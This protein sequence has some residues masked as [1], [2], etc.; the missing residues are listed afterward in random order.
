MVDKVS[1]VRDW[2]SASI[3]DQMLIPGDYL[4]IVAFYGKAEVLVSEAVN[5]D[6][7]KEAVK[8]K[9]SQISGNGRFT[10]IG[11]ALDAIKA[12]VAQRE[13]DGRGK[14][15]LLLTDGIQEAPPTSKYYSKDGSFNHEFLQNTKTIPEKGWKVVILG[16]GNDTQ[17]RDLASQLK[18]S[19]AEVSEK[20]TAASIAEAAGGVFDTIT[21]AEPARLSPVR[22]GGSSSVT[23]ALKMSGP[24]A[25]T[26]V[27]VSG[28]SATVGSRQ[29]PSLISAPV[30]LD[31]R[32]DTVTKLNFPVTFPPDLPTG[33]A[34]GT[35][36][37]SFSS[38]ATFSPATLPVNVAVNTPLQ[39]NLVWVIV[40]AAVV[41]VLVAAIVLVVRLLA[42][43]RPVSFVLVIDGEPVGEGPSTL[44]TGRQ[45]FLN[46]RS[47]A[48][49]LVSRRNARSIAGFEARNGLLAMAV[50]K[51]DRF[52]KLKE[53][54]EDARGRSFVLKT[55]NG[56]SV[57]MKVQSSER[58]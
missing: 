55:E 23:L 37:F 27:I 28:I 44:A 50:L 6:S 33:S 24:E 2:V 22:A 43:A 48:F 42:G 20:P 4:V 38:A 16:I 52:P 1:A 31:V 35:L 17:A 36:T 32:N 13:K 11:N 8:R 45:V 57:P 7:D 15:L 5:S 54:P 41:L 19:Y 49:S 29:V 18:G 53:V 56:R 40:G 39:N 51:Q 3:V 21:V 58:K 30:T 34:T 46:E 14:Y 47:G 12:Q 10:D 25:D 26:K 9:I